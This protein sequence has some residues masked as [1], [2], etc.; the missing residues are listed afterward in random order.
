MGVGYIGIALPTF[1]ACPK[2]KANVAQKPA[3]QL[4][5]YAIAG[6]FDIDGDG[7][8]DI[9]TVRRL[10]VMNG[11]VIDAEIDIHGNTKGKL[12]QDTA[13][14]IVGRLP[15]KAKAS[16]KVLQRYDAFMRRATKL[17][18]KIMQAEKM[19]F[20]GSRRATTKHDAGTRF[21]KRRLP[22]RRG[23]Y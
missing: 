21:R 23:G 22:L 1:A 12:R 19:L 20:K 16:A 4:V 18:L 6:M 15:D 2:Q 8:S 3:P 13:Y 9:E 5:R 14:L 11:G 10:I 17:D 7:K